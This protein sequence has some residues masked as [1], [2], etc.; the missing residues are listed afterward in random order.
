[1][2]VLIAM[3]DDNAERNSNWEEDVNSVWYCLEYLEYHQ[4]DI[5]Q[6]LQQVHKDYLHSIT[7]Y[8]Y[9]ICKDQGWVR[10]EDS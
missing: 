1:M 2:L 10:E 5:I 7:K 3:W 9:M 4:D 8:F 6:V